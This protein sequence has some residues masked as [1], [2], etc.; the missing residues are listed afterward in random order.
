[1]VL[2]YLA[3]LN[4]KTNVTDHRVFTN[5]IPLYLHDAFHS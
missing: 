4:N 2:I 1:M 3:I 5:T